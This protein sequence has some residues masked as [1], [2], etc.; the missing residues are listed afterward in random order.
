MFV[1]D[2]WPMHDIELVAKFADGYKRYVD[3]P[4][5]VNLQC[6]LIKEEAFSIAV[7]AGLRNI[8]VGIESGSAKIRKDVLV[9]NYRDEDA[10]RPFR[11]AREHRN[12]LIFIQYYWI[13][14]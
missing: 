1:D 9:R 8:C 7:D 11:L 12:P 5:S 10:I 13:A 6:K 3:L 4:F 2:I 14:I